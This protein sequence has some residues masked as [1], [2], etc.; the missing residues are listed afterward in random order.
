[1]DTVEHAGEVER[2]LDKGIELRSRKGDVDPDEREELWQKSIRD[3]SARRQEKNR[4]AWAAFH[5]GPAERHRCTLEDLIAH[6]VTQAAKLC[7]G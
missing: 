7:E 6:H 4:Q 2:E 5:E 1:M 3:Y